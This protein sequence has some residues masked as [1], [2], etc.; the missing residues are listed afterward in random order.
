[1]L[2]D[3]S[4]NP[5]IAISEFH[6]QCYCE[7]QLKYKWSGIKVET[8]E[9]KLGKQI[10]LGKLKDFEERMKEAEVV[11]INEAIRRAV[12]NNERFSAR[13]LMIKSLKFRIY[14]II[15]FVE[16]GPDGIVITDDKPGEYAFISVKSQL[17]GYALAFKDFYKP[18][19]DIMVV[20]KQR[21]TGD[22]VWED[23]LTEGWVE[24]IKEKIT[25]IQGL[26]LGER[27]FE[28]TKNPKKCVVCGYKDVCDKRLVKV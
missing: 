1:M 11:D 9:M 8:K 20:M 24:F 22:I 25:R 7:V 16:I 15:D 5:W 12:E 19:L 6:Q 17:L 4:G 13:E 23:F 26:A 14:G 18:P 27:E 28:P 2:M 21:D 10:H 3:E